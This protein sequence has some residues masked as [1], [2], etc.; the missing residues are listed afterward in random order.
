[1]AVADILTSMVVDMFLAQAPDQSRCPLLMFEGAQ[2]TARN[3]DHGTYL[4]SLQVLRSLSGE[5]Q[6]FEHGLVY[7]PFWVSSSLLDSCGAVRSRPKPLMRNWR[8]PLQA[9]NE[10]RRN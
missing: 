4:P 8:V 6:P 5:S 10:I 2:V 9:A 1:M 7:V 3:I